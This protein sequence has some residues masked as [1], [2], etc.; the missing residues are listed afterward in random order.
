MDLAGAPP[1]TVVG[2]R[3]AVWYQT[4]RTTPNGTTVGGPPVMQLG[5]VTHADVDASLG[6]V[7]RL[8]V[9][10]DGELDDQGLWIDNRDDWAWADSGAPPA[11]AQP[12][13]WSDG[14][15]V[16]ATPG[17]DSIFHVR[18]QGDAQ[19]FYVKW[20]GL[21]HIHCQWVPRAVLEADLNVK[22]RIKRFFDSRAVEDI[23][24][25]DDD[26]PQG[27]EGSGDGATGH[28]PEYLRVERV[29]AEAPR[30]GG[31]PPMYLVKWLGLPYSASTWEAGRHLLDAQPELRQF[32][33]WRAARRTPS[34]P[35]APLGSGVAP[36]IESP[37][38]KGDRALRD[39]QLEGLNWLVRSWHAGRCVMLADEMGL[40]K[41][42]QSVAMLDHLHRQ[43]G[44]RGPFLVVAPL[45]TLMHWKREVEQWTHMNAVVFHGDKASRQVL[46]AYEFFDEDD[47]HYEAQLAAD[48]T[49]ASKSDPVADA[50]QRRRRCGAC[51]AC[52]REACNACEACVADRGVGIT[53]DAVGR[54]A[55]CFTRRC[56][57]A[58]DVQRLQRQ[59]WL[60]TVQH[61]PHTATQ[62]PVKKLGQVV[63]EAHEA[64]DAASAMVDIDGDADDDE[65]V[66]GARGAKPKGR[67]GA[68]G[69]K[70]RGGAPAARTS[71]KFDVLI[72]SYEVVKE[73]LTELRKIAWRYMVV[74]EAHR[75]KSKDSALA[76]DLR[77]LK[78]AHFHLLTGTP[79]Q[80]NTSELWALCHFL[81][82]AQFPSLP[83]FLAEYGHGVG[84][85]LPAERASRPEQIEAMREAVRPYLLR[86]LKGDVEKNLA[87][88]EET[89]VWVEMTRFQK[90]IYRAALE[91][92]RDMLVRGVV[93]ASVSALNNLQM[94]LRKCCDHP[95][96]I[97]GVQASAT[98]G[99][100]AGARR[101]AFLSASGKLVLLDKLLPKLKAEGHCV[102]VFSQFTMMLDLLVDFLRERRFGF[103]RLDGNT[104]MDAR[105]AAIDRFGRE[106]G[107]DRAFVFLLSTRAGGVGINL[108]AADTCIIFDSDW[109]PQNDVQAMARCHRI[110]QSKRVKVFRLVTRN[111]YESALVEIANRK[112]GL[113]RALNGEGAGQAEP[114]REEVAKLLR[115][116]AHDIV[117]DDKDDTAFQRFS[118]SDIDQILESSTTV[119][120]ATST[121]G[122][123]FSK[124]SFA[125]DEGDLD[126]DDP[127]FWSK[128]L[129]ETQAAAAEPL[130]K[131]KPKQAERWQH[132]NLLFYE[133]SADSVDQPAEYDDPED[134]VYVPASDVR[135]AVQ[136][137]GDNGQPGPATSNSLAPPSK[138]PEAEV[139]REHG[140]KVHDF[141][142]VRSVLTG[143]VA[144]IVS[145]TD[146]VAKL[147]AKVQAREGRE[148]EKEERRKE[149]THEQIRLGEER[150]AQFLEKALNGRVACAKLD[151]QQNADAIR[152]L[153]GQLQQLM[154]RQLQ[155]QQ[156]CQQCLTQKQLMLQQQAEMQADWQ[157]CLMQQHFGTVAQP[158]Q[159]GMLQTQQQMQ[160]Q[161]LQVLQQQAQSVAA[162][163]AAGSERLKKH[164]TQLQA[165]QQVRAA[166]QQEQV[167][168][169]LQVLLSQ[170]I[171][172]Q[173]A[174]LAATGGHRSLPAI[175]VPA[176]LDVVCLRLR[177][178][179]RFALAFVRQAQ[180]KMA[181][182]DAIQPASADTVAPHMP[183][184]L[185]TAQEKENQFFE[186]ARPNLVGY[187]AHVD[188][189]VRSLEANTAA[190]QQQQDERKRQ[191]QQKQRWELQLWEQQVRQRQEE[192]A[193]PSRLAALGSI[194]MMQAMSGTRSIQLGPRHQAVVPPWQGDGM[195]SGAR[196]RPS[197]GAVVDLDDDDDDS[198][199]HERAT[200]PEPA[201][202]QL[203]AAR[204]LEEQAA[205]DIAVVL[206]GAAYLSNH[207]QPH[208]L[209]DD[210]VLGH[211]A[212]INSIAHDFLGRDASCAR[213][214]RGIRADVSRKKAAANGS[215]PSGGGGASASL[216]S[217]STSS[218]A[219]PSNTTPLPPRP[220]QPFVDRPERVSQLSETGLRQLQRSDGTSLSQHPRLLS[221]ARF[222]LVAHQGGLLRLEM[223]SLL[224]GAVLN[225]PH[226]EV[227][228]LLLP[229]P[230][231]RVHRLTEAERKKL[232]EEHDARVCWDVLSKLV[233]KVERQVLHEQAREEKLARK[234][235]EMQLRQQRLLE[236]RAK[237]QSE[238]E[239]RSV[240]NRVLRDVER[241]ME[242]DEK[243]VAREVSALTSILVR[244]V[245]AHVDQGHD[246]GSTIGHGLLMPT[247]AR[248]AANPWDESRKVAHRQRDATDADISASSIA[249]LRDYLVSLGGSPDLVAGW[250]ATRETRREGNSAGTTDIYFF[251]PHV[252]KKFRSRMEIARYLGF[253]AKKAAKWVQPVKMTQPAGGPGAVVAQPQAAEQPALQV[254]VP[255]QESEEERRERLRERHR[256]EEQRRRERTR[257]LSPAVPVLKCTRCGLEGHVRTN[258]SCPLFGEVGDE[259]SAVL[260][261]LI[262]QLERNGDEQQ[263]PFCL[264]SFTNTYKFGQHRR[265]CFERLC[266]ELAPANGELPLTSVRLKMRG[267]PLSFEDR[268]LQSYQ[269]AAASD[270]DARRRGAILGMGAGRSASRGRGGGRGRGGRGRGGS[271]DE[272]ASEADVGINA[273]VLR[274]AVQVARAANGSGARVV[275]K[276]SVLRQRKQAN[277][278]RADE[279]AETPPPRQSRPPKPRPDLE[280]RPPAKAQ[281]VEPG[282][283]QLFVTIRGGELVPV[284]S[285]LDLPF[286]VHLHP[287]LVR[288]NGAAK[289]WYYGGAVHGRPPASYDAAAPEPVVRSRQVAPQPS[290]PA[291]HEKE[292]GLLVQKILV[293]KK[294]S[295]GDVWLRLEFDDGRK[296]P[297][298]V[299]PAPL[300][301]SS[302]GRQM[303]VAYAKEHRDVSTYLATQQVNPSTVAAMDV[304]DELPSGSPWAHL[305]KRHKAAGATGAAKA[306]G[307]DVKRATAPAAQ[308][309]RREPSAASDSDGLIADFFAKALD[310][311]EEEEDKLCT[312][313]RR[314]DD[315]ASM[316]LCD[317]PGC[318]AGYHM[319]CLPTPLTV[320][321]EGDWFCPSCSATRPKKKKAVLAGGSKPQPPPSQ[322]P[323]P[324]PLREGSRVLARWMVDKEVAVGERSLRGKF[325]PGTITSL[326]GAQTC[327]I[328]FDDGDVERGVLLENVKAAPP[329]AKHKRPRPGLGKPAI[330]PPSPPPQLPRESV[331]WEAILVRLSG[332][333]RLYSSTITAGAAV[334]AQYGTDE[335]EGWW[336]GTV[337]TAHTE[338][339]HAGSFDVFYADGESEL[340]KPAKRV[341]LNDT[342]P[343]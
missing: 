248:P 316:L 202:P 23:D 159:F 280:A 230:P 258:Q 257:G 250:W 164:Q 273:R 268:L 86:R 201:E 279:A 63:V 260:N 314:G 81:D 96:L 139:A 123:V 114:N 294:Y 24:G 48:A 95:Y 242:R 89:V 34:Q 173:I 8:H 100:A 221:S 55:Y 205:A 103:E 311:V 332:G 213:L 162:A 259:V 75:L 94:E 163:V 143:I 98:A 309:V 244:Q 306:T 216:A 217:S 177:N 93:D 241:A 206:S 229:P 82:A 235:Q 283:P 290:T 300:L 329:Q 161:Q 185:A 147:E 21:A 312:S 74:D 71:T 26:E 308:P 343:L 61:V 83:A 187:Q 231:P 129:P 293:H 168:H 251:S 43:N 66:P 140:L 1:D 339:F 226:A 272:E 153:Q 228:P 285:A 255:A 50:R 252:K 291:T 186:R 222:F 335:D 70:A 165:A 269:T 191:L 317:G 52:M 190:M 73:E 323:A 331:Q 204:E 172:Q 42:A 33:E 87:P 330:Q 170:Q 57:H 84:H 215:G 106:D 36:L 68:A 51:E 210:N 246:L 101:D 130:G 334:E 301:Y 119:Q 107:A 174:Q 133:A 2:R 4:Y 271:R 10:F 20:K 289:T 39:Y 281:K 65:W 76:V 295:N 120:H 275:L 178:Q 209:S 267:W 15:S 181:A 342:Q 238:N 254:V 105:Q 326:E 264:R 155:L 240:L 263:C 211:F 219:P 265:F 157:Q 297:G 328:L 262:G 307:A 18:G 12:G 287:S 298:F 79:L 64:G 305:L 148:R 45:S 303:L 78:P 25:E 16:F 124:A 320:V 310:G 341:R 3:I 224:L 126:L 296:T 60:A 158:P 337:L 146:K 237:R 175:V 160:E 315:A 340:F 179:N 69:R 85:G 72:T 192:E 247:W 46:R 112:L 144:R 167:Q 266:A 336:P 91:K 169:A 207:N 9:A 32:R 284:S 111:T 245:E 199:A 47:A 239:V 154:Q 141:R 249:S 40:G 327:V 318:G 189:T 195:T 92:R 150:I 14:R 322:P 324:A 99:M 256:L 149:K 286:P 7:A 156:Q 236:E 208:Q 338:G 261:G 176:N 113:E 17:V 44:I 333:N 90:Q 37:L 198:P 56:A 22:R 292:S 29:V 5:V 243:Q 194:R 276:L 253:D 116:G 62:Q 182:E 232:E 118:Q 102:L 313:C 220:P 234:Q 304:T 180:L 138:R 58:T 270:A 203:V 151:E 188:S 299:N 137:A 11:P 135:V 38:Y 28:R 184:L 77:A 97:K 227:L 288:T 134:D 49:Q 196:P 13:V 325:F 142:A 171:A 321:P 214:A 104:H 225:R 108:T 27:Q 319:Q 197:S 35:L 277:R 274:A 41:T 88:L 54:R 282:S 110:G 117:I 212:A 132:P 59:A 166:A 131:R 30:G 80:N 53:A 115:Q 127:D 128:M 19:E 121:E 193:R 136:Q 233:L 278:L 302:A 67:Q 200:E 223:L 109:N 125:A 6:T 152:N 122:S 31:L 183:R 145:E 218:S